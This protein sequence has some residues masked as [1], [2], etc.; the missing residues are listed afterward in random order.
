MTPQ[1]RAKKAQWMQAWRRANKTKFKAMQRRY[2]LKRAYGLTEEGYQALVKQQNGCCAI[3]KSPADTSGLFVDHNHETGVV[4]GLLCSA[5]NTAL[6]LLRESTDCILAM[7]D[8]VVEHN[9]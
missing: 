7:L 9:G 8:Y 1:R 2:H 4:R 6:G 3:C 5:C